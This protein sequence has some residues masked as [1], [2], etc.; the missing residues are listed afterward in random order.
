MSLNRGQGFAVGSGN[1][2]VKTWVHWESQADASYRVRRKA[3]CG[4]C[5]PSHEIELARGPSA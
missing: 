1:P 3:V 4:A 5:S 2:A